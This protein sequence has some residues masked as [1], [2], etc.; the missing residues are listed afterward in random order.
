[1]MADEMFERARSAIEAKDL[2]TLRALVDAEP[3]L[4]HR[5]CPKHGG[6]LLHDA[7]YTNDV[8][9]CRFLVESGSATSWIKEKARVPDHK[10]AGPGSQSPLALALENNRLDAAGF[11]ATVEVAPDNLWMAASLGNLE[12]VRSFFDDAGGLA[13]GARDPNKAGDDAF[14]L[15]DALVGAVHQRQMPVAIELL[16]RGADPSGRDQ[17]GMTALHYAVQ[18]NRE[19]TEVLLG[20]GADV[21]IRD[22]QFDATPYGW[23]T[24]QGWDEIAALLRE[25]ADLDPR[26]RGTPA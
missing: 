20:R 5:R 14:V 11:L 24:F 22:L 1:M 16:D 15:A 3:E 19:L 6:N 17:F 18:G 25:R 9:L 13:P 21:R 8:E 2:P 26:D 7:A 12:R 4:A 10:R 23:A